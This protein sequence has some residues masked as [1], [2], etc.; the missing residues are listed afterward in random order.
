M[1]I[2]N[3]AFTLTELLLA[4][5]IVGTIAALSIPALMKDVNKKTQSSQLK[6]VVNTIDLAIVNAMTTTKSKDITNSVFG[7]PDTV[8]TAFNTAKICNSISTEKNKCWDPTKY[9]T[10]GKTTTTSW[11]P[12]TSYAKLKNG[13]S[14]GYKRTAGDEDE[15]DVIGTFYVDLNGSQGPNIIGRDTFAMYLTRQGKLKGYW[16]TTNSATLEQLKTNITTG[17]D[18]TTVATACYNYLILNSWIMDY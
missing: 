6:N 16:G 2:K 12:A 13:V 4:L 1:T 5:T 11:D 17:T 8:F 9:R 14:M 7:N 18:M 15:P 10:L 3:K